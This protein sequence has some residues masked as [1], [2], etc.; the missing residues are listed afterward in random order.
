MDHNQTL[1]PIAMGDTRSTIYRSV[2]DGR[3]SPSGGEL[4]SA[5][6][7]DDIYGLPSLGAMPETFSA[8]APATTADI[9]TILDHEERIN[10]M[11][12]RL[13]HLTGALAHALDE[14]H[15]LKSSPSSSVP[16]TDPVST[17][18]PIK[19]LSKFSKWYQ[20]LLKQNLTVANYL[21][22]TEGTEHPSTDLDSPS[23][24]VLVRQ[25]AERVNSASIKRSD[26]L[27]DR[28]V[29]LPAT[30]RLEQEFEATVRYTFDNHQQLV[31]HVDSNSS[32]FWI[33][34]AHD[35]CQKT[36]YKWLSDKLV[37]NMQVQDLVAG[38]F[39]LFAKVYTILTGPRN[40]SPKVKLDEIAPKSDGSLAL[41][42]QITAHNSSIVM[43][44]N[45]HSFPLS[46]PLEVGTATLVKRNRTT[47]QH[48]A[49]I[50]RA[51]TQVVDGNA[52]GDATNIAALEIFQRLQ[53][54]SR[55]KPLASRNM[56]NTGMPI[57]PTY[58]EQHS[59]LQSQSQQSLQHLQHLQQQ[60]QQQSLQ[61]QQQQQ[62]LQHQQQQQSLQQ[63]QQQQQSLQQQQQQQ[64]LQQQQQQQSLQQ[65]QQQQQSGMN[66]LVATN[67][68]R[69]GRNGQ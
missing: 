14:I 20:D 43:G 1:P 29:S 19:K 12:I 65:Q 8:T 31:D 51:T 67:T 59:H 47:P 38:Y 39:L 32:G 34:H 68:K 50:K 11:E 28:K 52:S 21:R 27:L 37:W 9:S 16:F 23:V 63:Q 13:A 26:G 64:S 40:R 3:V 4:L 58:S 46:N 45:S 2:D 55:F 56:M 30:S 41:D 17:A 35:I 15:R 62:S 66:A 33:S 10:N 25:L 5:S 54:D 42:G 18:Q 36:L 57:L 69:G 61:H 53:A 49:R 60:Q 48:R 22:L 7:T 6:R 44:L 24:K